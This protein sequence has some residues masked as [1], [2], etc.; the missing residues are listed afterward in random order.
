MRWGG[1]YSGAG[2]A[3]LKQQTCV[4]EGEGKRGDLAKQ[5]GYT[6]EIVDNAAKSP[7]AQARWHEQRRP[8]M[9]FV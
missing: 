7:Q 8:S 2:E 4:R 3:A 9:I 6:Q 1:P 5:A